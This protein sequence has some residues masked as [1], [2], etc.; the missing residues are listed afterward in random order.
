M[1]MIII[2]NLAFGLLIGFRFPLVVLIPACIINFV[3]A[4][5]TVWVG[6]A[7][8][9]LI[10]FWSGFVALQVAYL[11]GVFARDLKLNVFVRPAIQHG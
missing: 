8:S 3:Q 7:S 5:A 11:C 2:S 4:L 6:E 9:F 1:L 10:T